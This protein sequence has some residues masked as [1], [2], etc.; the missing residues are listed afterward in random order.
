MNTKSK[1]NIKWWGNKVG[2][3]GSNMGGY[4]PMGG[5]PYGPNFG[6]NFGSMNN[7]SMNG[8]MD[9]TD[10]SQRAYNPN[11]P[12]Y[13]HY[14]PKYLGCQTGAKGKNKIMKYTDYTYSGEY[15]DDEPDVYGASMPFVQPFIIMPTV[16]QP[17]FMQQQD[18]DE[19][20]Y[21]APRFTEMFDEEDFDG[22]AG[23]S[24]SGKRGNSF[25]FG[26]K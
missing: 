16:M 14:G 25:G 20:E 15:D 11:D 12:D 13:I 26:N 1:V 22:A 21:V 9:E 5:Q 2:M 7:G 3:Q 4:M 18:N 24:A 19:P 17:Q 8:S 6:Q 10:M 23:N